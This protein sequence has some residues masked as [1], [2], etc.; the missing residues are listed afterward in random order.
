MTEMTIQ[1]VAQETGLSEHTLR[2]YERIGLIPPI[3]RA[4]N[5][6][7][8]YS[9]LN[10]SQIGFVKYLRATGMSISDIQRYMQLAE[11][12]DATIYERLALLEAHQAYVQEQLEQFTQFLEMISSKIS[13][14]RDYHQVQ[15]EEELA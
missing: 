6:H 5:G 7:R 3:E 12:G 8:R 14:Y 11:Q 4:S 2:Y 15:T 10:L 13:H 1:N 9:K